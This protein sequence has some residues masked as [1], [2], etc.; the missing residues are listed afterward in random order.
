MSA[1]WDWLR[2]YRVWEAVRRLF[3]YAENWLQPER[4]EDRSP[5]GTAPFDKASVRGD[6]T[7]AHGGVSTQGNDGAAKDRT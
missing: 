4:R 5:I 7:P 6:Q 2:R 1:S 3:L